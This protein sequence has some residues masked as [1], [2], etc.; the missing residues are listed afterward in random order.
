M[1]KT[2][3]TKTRFHVTKKN[4]VMVVV[5]VIGIGLAGYVAVYPLAMEK[6]EKDNFKKAR[7]GLEDLYG[8]IEAKIGKPDQI[9]RDQSCA[10]A[11]REFVRGP[12]SCGSSIVF[13][14]ENK[15]FEEVNSKMSQASPL[16]SNKLYPGAGVR[17]Q[18]Q[19][20]PS[21]Q[22]NNQSFGQDYKKF[23]DITCSVNYSY[24]VYPTYLSNP[25]QTHFTENFQIE[26]SCGGSARAEYFPVKN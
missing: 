2:V 10:Y 24:P 12:R 20:I 18:T 22:N 11:S 25:F 6:I 7:A 19:F 1:A 21:S 26:L 5:L 17:H 8:Q 14:Y 4:W 9:K 23:G 15:S 13:L 16:V 3:S